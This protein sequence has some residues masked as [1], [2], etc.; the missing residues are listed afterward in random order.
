MNNLHIM[1]V[2]KYHD[3]LAKIVKSMECFYSVMSWNFYEETNE[4]PIINEPRYFV[5]PEEFPEAHKQWDSLN[6]LISKTRNKTGIKC[7]QND[8]YPFNESLTCN[9]FTVY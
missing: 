3:I 4:Q 6:P 2:D 1:E 5:T 9:V 7:I 8:V